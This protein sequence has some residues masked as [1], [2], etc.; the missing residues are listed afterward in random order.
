MHTSWKAMLTTTMVTLA[1]A[2]PLTQASA[3]TCRVTDTGTGSGSGWAQAASLSAALANANC[4]EIW[5]KQG[6]YS[7][8]A[9]ARGFVIDRNLK[10]YGGFEGT[11]A[12]LADRPSPVDASATVLD[13]QGERRVLLVDGTT[14]NGSITGETLIDGLSLV[15][16]R[17]SWDNIG[18]DDGGGMQCRARFSGTACTPRINDVIFRDNQA[19]YGGGLYNN[20]IEGGN[21]SPVLTGVTFSGNTA[22]SWGGALFNEAHDGG[23]ASPILT[24]VTFSGNSARFYGGAVG[25]GGIDGGEAKPVMT[26]VTFIANSAEWGGGAIYSWGPGARTE[27][28]NAV[29]WSNTAEQDPQAFTNDP[30]T[31]ITFINSLIQGDTC[32][33][34]EAG[35]ITC[36][37]LIT[38]NPLLGPLADNGGPT[39]T[40][41]PGPGSAAI[42]AVDC[43]P[44]I[45]ADQRGV[46]R[47]QNAR[48]DLGAVEVRAATQ[49]TATVTGLGTVSASSGGLTSCGESGGQCSASYAYTEAAPTPQLVALTAVPGT[50]QRF[51]NW[52][53]DCTGSG[54]CMVTMDRVRNVAAVF[55]VAEAPGQ[56]VQPVPTLGGWAL[57]LLSVVAGLFGWRRQPG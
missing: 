23:S 19:T 31:R 13:G 41:L 28:R 45:N 51:S 32:P 40:Y 38:G 7:Q 25:S 33:N 54:A 49:L 36:T 9:N 44:G 53:G 29:L 50:G 27:V 42:D 52:E 12:T 1:W 37:G 17:G 22:S 2:A 30:D 16:G 11:E 26:H 10:L 35:T 18:D 56:G 55:A 43:S 3:A 20:S 4:T 57:L 15:N 24:H 6:T 34:G 21:S 14:V 8:T 46:A 48:C 5:I 47:P 39:P